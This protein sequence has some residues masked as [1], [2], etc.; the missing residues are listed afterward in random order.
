MYRGVSVIENKPS[1]GIALWKGAIRGNVETGGINQSQGMA[2][3][4]C[5][6]LSVNGGQEQGPGETEQSR[7]CRSHRQI[8]KTIERERLGKSGFRKRG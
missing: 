1:R 7:R 8:L 3:S 6:L 5:L 2:E 4:K